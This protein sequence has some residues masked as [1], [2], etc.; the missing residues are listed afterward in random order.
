MS[1]PAQ[2]R[3]LSL[4]T[5]W[6]GRSQPWLIHH[7]GVEFTGEIIVAESPDASWGSP[8]TAGLDFRLVFFTV[9]R[10]VPPDQIQDRRIAMAV[11]RCLP[12]QVRPTLDRELQAIHEARA[13]YVTARD[14]DT[15]TLRRSMEEREASVREELARRFAVA[16]SQGRIYTHPSVRVRPLDVFEEETAVSWAD[17]L[18]TS[19]LS[20]AYP[21]L[22]YDNDAF[23]HTLTGEGVAAGFRGLFNGDADAKAA[24]AF[25]PGLGL[26][27]PEPPGCSTPANVGPSPSSTGRWR[28]GEERCRPMKRSVC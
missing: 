22:L 19:M 4:D 5:E 27:W 16:F 2:T 20:L 7:R 13:R 3:S 10:R 9:P 24:A 1:S 11:P 25:G 8:L 28:H 12:H 6:L 23:P 18:A 26:V 17:R 15:L 14:V 21:A